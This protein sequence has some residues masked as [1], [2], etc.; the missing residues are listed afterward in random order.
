MEGLCPTPP[1]TVVSVGAGLMRPDLSLKLSFCIATFRGS[2][3]RLV[4]QCTD[5]VDLTTH[6]C[7][8]SKR[9]KL[10]RVRPVVE[11][12]HLFYYYKSNVCHY[13]IFH[14]NSSW[15][16]SYSAIRVLFIGMPKPLEDHAVAACTCK[17]PPGRRAGDSQK[18]DAG[19]SWEAHRLSSNIRASSHFG[20]LRRITNASFMNLQVSDSKPDVNDHKSDMLASLARCSVLRPLH[21]LFRRKISSFRELSSCTFGPW[22]A[23]CYVQHGTCVSFPATS[24]ERLV[25]CLPMSALGTWEILSW[26]TRPPLWNA[27]PA[28]A[29]DAQAW[30]GRARPNWTLSRSRQCL[31]GLLGPASRLTATSVVSRYLLSGAPIGYLF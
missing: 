3:C 6:L 27:F 1:S 15:S 19:M 10:R 29:V 13:N 22:H 16:C 7:D 28:P 8:S 11:F 24:C 21:P 17:R 25:L 18:K 23:V 4:P 20:E 26:L 31:S 2:Q 30:P 5:G 12:L 9:A 14:S